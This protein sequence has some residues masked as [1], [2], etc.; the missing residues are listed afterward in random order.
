MTRLLAIKDK[1]VKFYAEYETYLFPVIKFIISLVAFEMIRTNIGFNSKIDMFAISMVLALLCSLLPVNAIIWFAAI[2]V[3]AE[4]ISVSLETA[5][6]GVIL[7]TIIYFIYFRFT[8]KDGIYAILTPICFRLNIPYVMPITCGLLKD[9][10]SVVSVLCGTVIFYFLDGI[11]ESQAILREQAKGD[12]AE[13]FAK[14]KVAIGTVANNR[15]M[16]L[17][18]AIFTITAIAVYL[19]RRLKADN[20]WLL[21]IIIGTLIQFIGLFIGYMLIPITGET[22][23][24]IIGNVVALI[25][26]FLLRFL[27]MNL[28]Y[29]RTERVQF[30]DDEYY[31]YVKAVPKKTVTSG[32]KTVKHFGN[33]SSIGKKIN[34]NND[35]NMAK[36]TFIDDLN[37][38]DK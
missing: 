17:V 30:E 5:V 15:E 35:N 32:S 4:L 37:L 12:N 18:L 1:A 11:K 27:F 34:R 13:A 3:I 25:T 22:V 31:Y 36:Q 7:F 33:T 29:A 28:D 6:V 8:P 14:F 10:Y 16:Y 2:L 24:L 26:G 9:A 20:A 38:G 19:I 21:A 23:T